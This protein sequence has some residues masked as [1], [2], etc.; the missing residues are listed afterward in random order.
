MA[1]VTGILAVLFTLKGD[2][3]YLKGKIE[4]MDKRLIRI[5]EKIDK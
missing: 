3:G 1:M 4:E 5:K 2:I